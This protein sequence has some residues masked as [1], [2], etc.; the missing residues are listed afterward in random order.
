MQQEPLLCPWKNLSRLLFSDFSDCFV[1]CV[2][3][4]PGH[5][6]FSVYSQI[7]ILSKSV[8]TPTRK[9]KVSRIVAA[10]AETLSSGS[11]RN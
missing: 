4:L 6:F 7:D 9:K 1:S 10:A 8:V 11:G 5:I 3:Y 2:V